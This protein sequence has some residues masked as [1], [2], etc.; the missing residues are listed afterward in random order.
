MN[1]ETHEEFMNRVNELTREP[2]LFEKTEEH[3]GEDKFG[4]RKK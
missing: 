1:K 4:S 3:F 2:T